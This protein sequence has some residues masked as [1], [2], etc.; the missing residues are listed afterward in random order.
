MACGG[1]HRREQGLLYP[2]WDLA[3]AAAGQAGPDNAHSCQPRQRDRAPSRC[4]YR[5]RAWAAITTRSAF[6][7]RPGWGSERERMK[8]NYAA[9]KF[10]DRRQ[11]DG[12]LTEAEEAVTI[13]PG[14][15][16]LRLRGPA[17]GVTSSPGRPS[18]GC[19][20]QG[21]G[22]VRNDHPRRPP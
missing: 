5:T 11:H 14:A 17:A 22:T 1:N 20:C 16:P 6:H 8:P 13:V 21:R 4:R 3:R 15:M 9:G 12:S 7:Q 18:V 19:V 2:S 10:Y